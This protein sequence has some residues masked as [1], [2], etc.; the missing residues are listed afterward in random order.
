MKDLEL[1][2]NYDTKTDILSRKDIDTNKYKFS[3]TQDISWKWLSSQEIINKLNEYYHNN[4]S[5]K[6]IELY[7]K[8]NEEVDG[9]FK[10]TKIINMIGPGAGA[11]EVVLTTNKFLTI[12]ELIDSVGE[13][14]LID[15]A[16]NISIVAIE[17]K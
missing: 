15:Y 5:E 7:N 1:N 17:N 8:Y 9:S 14:Y 13:D 3:F 16:W 11:P 2:V 6:F 12:Q 4:D 10:I